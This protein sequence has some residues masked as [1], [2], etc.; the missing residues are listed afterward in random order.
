[1]SEQKVESGRIAEA[2]I[3]VGKIAAGAVIGNTI[4]ASSISGNHLN[5]NIVGTNNIVTGSVTGNILAASS[6]S[7]NHLNPGIVGTNNI[8]AGS[9]TGNL[10]AESAVG[11]N[12]LTPNLSISLVRVFESANVFT[13]GATGNVIIN[14]LNNTV[15]FFSSNTTGN[16]TFNFRANTQNTLD[17]QL[18]LGQSVTSAIL[19]KQG[20]TRYRA[21]VY[22]DDVLQ[23][24]WW[25]GNSAPGFATEQQESIDLY[26]FNILKTAANTYTVLASNSNFALAQGQIS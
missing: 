26:S 7:G 17:S 2:S 10:I 24:V 9:V 20:D 19:L 3:I 1:M 15:Y 8:V 22:V 5:P 6:I 14:V 23:T 16:V 25:L 4:A 21:N 18:S 11:S 13:T 12:T